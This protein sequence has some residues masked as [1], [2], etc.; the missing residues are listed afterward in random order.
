VGWSFG[1]TPYM[2]VVVFGGK[3]ERDP[4]GK[5]I[6]GRLMTR[7]GWRGSFVSRHRTSRNVTRL[8]ARLDHVAE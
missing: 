5:R 4:T 3:E 1:V 6:A 7:G 8:V 2:L